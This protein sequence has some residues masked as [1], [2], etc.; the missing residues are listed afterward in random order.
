MQEPLKKRNIA[1]VSN[2][3]TTS[4][5]TV[6]YEMNLLHLWHIYKGCGKIDIERESRRLVV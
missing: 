2:N 1:A 4:V 3:N 5:P 6:V